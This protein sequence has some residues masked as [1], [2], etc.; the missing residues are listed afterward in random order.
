MAETIPQVKCR[1]HEED[2]SFGSFRLGLM[3]VYEFALPVKCPLRGPAPP[4]CNFH[5]FPSHQT[6]PAGGHHR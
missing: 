1:G 6:M 5:V 4:S 3:L 2:Q